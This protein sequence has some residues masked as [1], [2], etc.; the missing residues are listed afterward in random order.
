MPHGSYLLNAGSVDKEKLEKTRN[1]LVDEVKRCQEL[2]IKLYNF[3]PGTIK[4]FYLLA[5]NS[6]IIV[7]L[8]VLQLEI[9]QRTI[10]SIA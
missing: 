8:Q 2:G 9:S 10:A 1:A 6:F 7:D 3:H 5:S 4:F